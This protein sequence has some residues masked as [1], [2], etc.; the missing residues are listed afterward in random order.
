MV[1]IKRFKRM[2]LQN[3]FVFGFVD[4]ILSSTPHKKTL[5][6]SDFVKRELNKLTNPIILNYE[7]FKIKLDRNSSHDRDVFWDYLQGNYY[8]PLLSQIL[9]ST[10]RVGDTFLDIGANNGFFSLLASSLV[11]ADG[12]VLAFEPTISTFRRLNEN[13]KLNC[14]KNI[15]SF[16]IALGNHKGIVTFYDFGTID[17]SNSLVKMR[18]GR[19]VKVSMDTLD[20]ILD[21]HKIKPNFLKI[22]VE[23]FEK[24]VLEGGNESILN[25]RHINLILE[26]NRHIL[27]KKGEPYSSVIKLL[28]NNGFEVREIDDSEGLVKPNSVHNHKEVNPFGCNLFAAK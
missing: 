23:G 15:K 5:G 16:N 24:E 22:D 14:F 25:S 18:G 21:Q 9:K 7:S 12:I 19:A 20:N 13:I 27:R 10:L 4:S 11:G 26:Y 28:V 2:V 1:L 8:D 3:D 17:G 6:N